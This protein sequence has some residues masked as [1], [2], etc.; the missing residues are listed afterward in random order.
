MLRAAVAEL[1]S[2]GA[3][4]AALGEGAAEVGGELAHEREAHVAL[5]AL[6]FV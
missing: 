3:L 5:E 2:G 1:E 4:C 6:F